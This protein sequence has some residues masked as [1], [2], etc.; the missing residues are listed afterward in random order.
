MVDIRKKKL[1]LMVLSCL[2]MGGGV[3]R[4][5]GLNILE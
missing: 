1:I 3:K 4:V 2:V 5:S